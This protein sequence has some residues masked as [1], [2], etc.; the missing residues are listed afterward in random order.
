MPALGPSRRG[1]RGVTLLESVMA[2]FLLGILTTSAFGG[3]LFGITG[4]HQSHARMAAS[5]WI[6]AEMDYLLLQGYAGLP[7]STRTLTPSATYTTF[8]QYAEPQIPAGFDHAVVD[9]RAVQGVSVKQ[10]TISLYQAPSAPPTVFST[11][12]SNFTRP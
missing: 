9:V 11:Y 8:G 4:A 10:V 1:E 7:L 5:A 12:I 6:Q 2:T 3:L